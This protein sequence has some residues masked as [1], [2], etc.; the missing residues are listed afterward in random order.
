MLSVAIVVIIILQRCIINDHTIGNVRLLSAN[1][2][3]VIFRPSAEYNLYPPEVGMPLR[4]GDEQ[5]AVCMKISRA[6]SVTQHRGN[7]Y[8]KRVRITTDLISFMQ[9]RGMQ[10]RMRMSA[11]RDNP[12]IRGF[13]VRIHPPLRFSAPLVTRSGLVEQTDERDATS[14]REAARVYLMQHA[15]CPHLLV[16]NSEMQFSHLYVGYR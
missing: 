16:I 11:A 9:A 10:S 7:A 6:S 8:R 13:C 14:G 4:I 3:G 15:S 2:A 1:A 12:H 5:R